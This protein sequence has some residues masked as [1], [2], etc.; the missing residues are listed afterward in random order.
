MADYGYM[1]VTSTCPVVAED[2]DTTSRIF[3]KD[4]ATIYRNVVCPEGH[5]YTIAI[6]ITVEGAVTE[7]VID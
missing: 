2:G 3:G 4:G 7:Y 6:A 1:E 5:T